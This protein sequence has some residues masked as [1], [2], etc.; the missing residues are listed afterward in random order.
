MRSRICI[1]ALA[2]MAVSRIAS[3][4]PFERRTLSNGSILLVSAQPSLPMVVTQVI[5]EAGTRRDPAGKDGVANL[6]ADLL[7]EGAGKRTAAEIHDAIDSLGAAISSG[8]D[9][10]FATTTLVVLKKDLDTGLGL[11]AD[12]LLRPTFADAEVNRRREAALA[13]LHAEEDQPGQ[14]AGRRFVETVFAGEPYGH[15]GQGSLKSVAA[16]TRRDVVAFHHD[17][18]RPNGAIISVAGDTT[19]DEMAARLE[20]L[21]AAWKPNTTAPFQYGERRAAAP[22]TL[23]INKPLTQTNIILGH[24]GIERSSPDYF[25]A[26]MMNFIFGGGGF[27]SRLMESV[28][29]KGGLAY[30][31]SSGFSV[32]QSPGAFQIVMQTKNASAADAIRKTCAEV[33]RMRDE[34]VTDEDLA[35]AKLYLTGSFPLRLDTNSKVAGFLGQ[36]EFYGLGSDYTDRYAERVNAVTKEDVHRAARQYLRPEELVMVVVGNLDE[37]KIGPGAACAAETASPPSSDNPS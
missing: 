26:N 5:L 14:V 18:Y 32:N 22:Q 1:L 10:D 35:N 16:L 11:L 17:F 37:A 25:A 7:T 8:T 34:L 36:V 23:T 33:Q 6:T 29:V 31:V 15:P 28:R 24:R 19:A 27:T 13:G 4:L 20:T 30:S 3:A 21:F 2:L 12:V 9:E